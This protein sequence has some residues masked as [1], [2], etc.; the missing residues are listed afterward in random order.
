MAPIGSRE[1]VSVSVRANVK[2]AF[3]GVPADFLGTAVQRGDPPGVS[4]PHPVPHHLTSGVPLEESLYLHS[5]PVKAQQRNE[6]IGRR[7]SPYI[8]YVKW[9]SQR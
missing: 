6:E 4:L 8:M 7:T 9:E 3:G 5:T 1:S 2:K